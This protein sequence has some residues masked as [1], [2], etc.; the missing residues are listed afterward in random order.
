M[1]FQASLFVTAFEMNATHIRLSEE[2]NEEWYLP[3]SY[4]IPRAGAKQ[5]AARYVLALPTGRT[6]RRGNI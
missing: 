1:A 4:N 2:I 6:A 5:R 3:Y